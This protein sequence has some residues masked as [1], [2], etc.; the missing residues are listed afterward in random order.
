MDKSLRDLLFGMPWTFPVFFV[1]LWCGIS[2]LIAWMSGW[3]EL[4]RRFASESEPYGDTLSAGPWFIVVYLR[5]WTKYGGVV[6]MR[7]AAGG[8]YLSAIFLFRL[9]HPPLRIPWNEI[10]V[11]RTRY[12]MQ[13]YVELTLGSE[14]RIPLRIREGT[15]RM[16]GLLERMK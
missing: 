8:L 7:A 11:G 3:Q 5:Y 16:L 4:A 9:G 1:C 10:R 2:Y 14:E 13:N 12:C 6:R 15:A